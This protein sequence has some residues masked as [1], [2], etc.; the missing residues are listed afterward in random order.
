LTVRK[1]LSML[2]QTQLKHSKSNTFEYFF[3]YR[4]QSY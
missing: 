4:A 2:S 3:S 1:S